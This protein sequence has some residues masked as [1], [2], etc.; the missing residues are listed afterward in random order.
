M[1][2]LDLTRKLRDE[3]H[4]RGVDVEAYERILVNRVEGG[5]EA[6]VSVEMS[7]NALIKGKWR[8]RAVASINMPEDNFEPLLANDEKLATF[9]DMGMRATPAGVRVDLPSWVAEKSTAADK[10]RAMNRASS[11]AEDRATDA[12]VANVLSETDADEEA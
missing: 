8:D 2:D 10:M 3:L 11:L 4:T 6:R 5:E 12:H 1:V 7:Y 9:L